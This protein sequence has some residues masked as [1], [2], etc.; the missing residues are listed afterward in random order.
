MR[1]SEFWDFTKI[2]LKF[3]IILVVLF[4]IFRFVNFSTAQ[5]AVLALAVGVGY[6]AYLRLKGRGASE[7]S[8]IPYQVVI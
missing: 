2:L 7:D 8:F 4:A 3:V 5:S 1:L 6:D